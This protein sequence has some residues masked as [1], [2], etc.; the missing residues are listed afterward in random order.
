VANIRLFPKSFAVDYRFNVSLNNQPV[1]KTQVI[2]Q[3][4]PT[5]SNSLQVSGNFLDPVNT[6]TT[7]ITATSGDDGVAII[8]GAQLVN[9]AS[10]HCEAVMSEALDGR[11]LA[12]QGNI[13]AGVSQS[14]QLV[15]L[16][17]SGATDALVYAVRSNADDTNTLMGGNGKIIISFNRPVEIVPGTADCQVAFATAPDTDGDSNIGR[18]ITDVR[19]NPPTTSSTTSESVSADLSGDG[20]TLTVG[21]KAELPFDPDDR[22]TSVTFSGVVLRPRGATDNSQVRYLGSLGTCPAVSGFTT[23]SL[24]NL[25]AGG[26]SQNSTIKLY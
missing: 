10:Y 19:N 2:C 3:Y 14:E 18:L 7:T 21:F 5:S 17:A 20:L 16:S 12:G 24:K 26:I 8:P 15:A 25:R 6:G 22:G 1:P 23:A 9:G 11:T 13:T 4:L